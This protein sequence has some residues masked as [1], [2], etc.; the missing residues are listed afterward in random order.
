[1]SRDTF[2]LSWDK[3]IILL[4]ILLILFGGMNNE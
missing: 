4:L 2:R 1:M 3:S